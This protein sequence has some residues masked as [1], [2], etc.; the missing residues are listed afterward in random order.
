MRIPVFDLVLL[1]CGPDGH[2]CSLFPGHAALSG[3]HK[4][5]GG[6]GSGSGSGSS[7]TVNDAAWV[8][9]IADSPK[10]PPARVTLSMEVVVHAAK[11]GFV[12]TG[13]GKSDV[14]RR[15]FDEGGVGQGYAFGEGGGGADERKGTDAM[16]ELPSAM[17]N[18]LAG[19]KVTWFTD[20]GAV[21]DVK[22]FEVK[23][24]G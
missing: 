6:S 24:I 8:R 10:P 1:G 13:E 17:V 5:G 16:V 12:T 11:V 4:D 23:R 21:A 22:K 3:Y 2:T 15:I 20:E 19:D 18:R 14:L 7:T 9:P